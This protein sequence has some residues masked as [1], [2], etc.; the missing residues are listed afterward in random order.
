MADSYEPCA[1]CPQ[2]CRHVCPVAVATGRE[3]A[4]PAKMMTAVL[5]ARRGLLPPIEAA[6]AAALCTDCGAC[7]EHCKYGIEVPRLLAEARNAYASAVQPQPLGE[8]DGEGQQVA[9]ECDGRPWAAALARQLDQPTAR[10]ETCDHLGWALLEH[11]ERAA[12]HLTRL[13]A[14]LAGRR[15]VTSC[16]HC[17][18]VLD[19]ARIGHAWLADLVPPSWTG[20]VHPCHGHGEMPGVPIRDPLACC[21]AHGPLQ[22]IHPSLAADVAKEAA[23]RLPSTTVATADATCRNALRGAGATVVDP[24]DLL[25]DP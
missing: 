8:I 1:F 19:A 23:T 9:I 7:Q 22:R 15:A 3:A 4:T 11:R 18:A 2:L 6:E 13:H 25:I 12:A 21:G 17:R 14:L 5:L 16:G 20:P 10:L 24:I